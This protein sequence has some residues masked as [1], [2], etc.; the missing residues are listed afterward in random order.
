VD[1]GK[2]LA[3]ESGGMLQSIPDTYPKISDTIV[4]FRTFAGANGSGYQLMDVH[5]LDVIRTLFYI[6]YGTLDC[7]SI[8]YGYASG[9]YSATDTAQVAENNTNRI[10]VTNTVANFFR[11]GQA[12]S[13][14]TSLG[15]NQIFYGRTITS[16]TV[17]DAS[18][19]AINFDGNP[20]DIS[21]GN[22]VYNS[23]WK[24]GFSNSISALSGS[25]NDNTSGYY[26]FVYRG[27]ENIWGNIIQFVDGINISSRVGWVC[28]SPG[29]YQSDLFSAPY[30]PLNY[31]NISSNGTVKTVGHDI[32]YPYAEFPI[33]IFGT[34]ASSYYFDNYSQNTL[35]RIGLCGGSFNATKGVGLMAWNFNNTSSSASHLIGGRLARKFVL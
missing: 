21:I 34:A 19:K 4:N 25:I 12:I 28:E 14:G 2:Y 10:V 3:T 24:N 18:T 22:I 8:M 15:G 23:A 35:T 31:T 30:F 33:E 1:I 16:I 6:E 7:Q 17:R 11:V 27:I 9:R 26:P 32:S 20:V 5:I 13:V 29:L